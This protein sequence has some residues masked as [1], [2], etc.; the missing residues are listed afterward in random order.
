MLYGVINET[1]VKD[2]LFFKITYHIQ[3]KPFIFFLSWSLAKNKP[4]RVHEGTPKGV[5][6]DEIFCRKLYFTG[7]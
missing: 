1:H 3:E 4:K 6:E 7:G 5:H 2:L